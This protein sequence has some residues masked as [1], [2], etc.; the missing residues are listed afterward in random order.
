MHSYMQL[1][2]QQVYDGVVKY[3]P[4]CGSKK[5]MDW[6]YQHALEAIDT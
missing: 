1:N 3:G 2:E 4:A 6:E 5:I